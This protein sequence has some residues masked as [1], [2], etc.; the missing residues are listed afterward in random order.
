VQ[1]LEALD[2][3]I[4]TAREGDAADALISGVML[5]RTQ[6]FR[7]LQEEGLER[8]S[9]LGLPFD[10][11]SSEAVQ[12]RAVTD[13]DQDGVVIE[14]LQ[15]GHHLRGHIIRRAKV[16]VGEYADE[17]PHPTVAMPA[18]DDE[19]AGIE[20]T[21]AMP[22]LA[23]PPEPTEPT[24]AMPVLKDAPAP[25]EPTVTMPVLPDR[26]AVKGPAPVKAPPE[27]AAPAKAPST[28]AVVG[29][30]K[31]SPSA[32][33][34]PPSPPPLRATPAP[35]PPTPTPAA[36]E[37]A[38]EPIVVEDWTEPTQVGRP[39][40]LIGAP[41]AR[42]TQPGD[43]AWTETQSDAAAPAIPRRP[44]AGPPP[45]PPAP[46]PAP[47]PPPA[48]EPPEDDDDSANATMVLGDSAALFVRP[49]PPPVPS[50]GAAAT[51]PA[52]A[53][54]AAQWE[55]VEQWPG[56]SPKE[57]QP[58]P[59][60][61]R[62]GP[63]APPAGPPH[64]RPPARPAGTAATGA[65]PR[66]ATTP[67]TLHR[68]RGT[69]IADVPTTPSAPAVAR[70]PAAVSRTGMGPRPVSG[71]GRGFYV[72]VTFAIVVLLGALGAELWLLTHREPTAAGPGTAQ[73]SPAVS[74]PPAAPPTTIPEEV[75]V[76][77]T[78]SGEVI[79]APTPAATPAGGATPAAPPV[80]SLPTPIPAA[81]VIAPPAA[82]TPPP[83]RTV[84]PPPANPV[85]GLLA[86]AEQAAAARRFHE[87]ISRYNDVLK[88]EPQNPEATAGKLHAMGDLAS[89]GRFFRTDLTVSEGKASGGGIPGFED[90][91]VVKS[92]CECALMYEVAPANPVQGQPYSVTIFL[93]NDSKKDIKPQ[94]ISVKVTVNGS[95]SN[96]PATLL[97][98]EVPKGQRMMVGRLQDTWNLGT[99]SWLLEAAV[100]AGGNTYRAQLTWDLPAGQ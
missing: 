55:S 66:T 5:V 93:R 24:V 86:Q 28:P 96:R 17:S 72:G 46:R 2:R 79:P 98:K 7:I 83:A 88:I 4:D 37:S 84:A 91:Q 68:A 38:D 1:T 26:A 82:A 63:A 71:H 94:T 30:P 60:D 19:P 52:E 95:S 73:A 49:T 51:A 78:P 15:G 35:T 74:T 20:P 40:T 56:S 21:M 81:P 50:R 32:T 41:A 69:G 47:P 87:A 6:L 10:P 77:T 76:V 100:G 8:V 13:P 45:I 64:T 43:P 70:P 57:T 39:S 27:K 80:A 61:N 34:P 42:A 14:E 90:A 36:A 23:P 58:V 65:R 12:R 25:I 29:P 48:A 44:A 3:A 62:V 59:R 92:K 75:T 97:S 85:P 31:P 9:V 11:R 22:A 33:A 54:Q 53:A 16:V 89:I 18:L 99:T 67:S